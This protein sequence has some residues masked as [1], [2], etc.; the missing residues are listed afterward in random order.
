MDLLNI[1]LQLIFLEFVD[2]RSNMKILSDKD[3]TTDLYF[4]CSQFILVI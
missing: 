4:D 3:K 2:Q 1:S